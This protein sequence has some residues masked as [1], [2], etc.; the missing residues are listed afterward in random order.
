M[1]K[2]NVQKIDGCERVCKAIRLV[3]AFAMLDGRASGSKYI[4]DQVSMRWFADNDQMELVD[5]LYDFSTLD[6]ASP[7]PSLK[8]VSVEEFEM[9]IKG[10][11]NE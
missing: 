1:A 3:D 9:V 6:K 2:K 4:R 5:D 7:I 11:Y 8:G 10:R